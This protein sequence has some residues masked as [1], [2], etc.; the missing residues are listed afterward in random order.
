M[1]EKRIGVIYLTDGN[2][3]D[4]T[5]ASAVALGLN[6]AREI[7][8]HVVQAG[9][10]SEPPPSVLRFLQSKGHRLA[11]H[12]L[13]AVDR[14][15][16]GNRHITP[17]AYAKTEAIAVAS[18]DHDFACYVDNDTLAMRP[19]DLAAVAP[20]KHPFGAAPDLSVSTGFDNPAFF[21]NCDRHGLAK[22]YFNSGLLAINVSRWACSG[23]PERYESAVKAHADFCPYWDGSCTDLDQCALN[24]ATQGQW[25][26]LPVEF[27]VQ[28][29][30]FQ[31]RFW[32]QALI[33]HYTGPEKFLPARS[34]RADRHERAVLG[35]IARAC[36]ELGLE[37][38]A[39]YL[40]LAYWANGL[41]RKAARNRIS[42][43][44]DQYFAI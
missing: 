23:I 43:L 41:R 13:S 14:G 42:R 38:P 6:H 37:I 4:L 21:A 12:S 5:Y 24:I 27:N 31:T 2:R 3:D 32:S 36:P 19:L 26:T 9:F 40:G 34:H 20:R 39:G 30:A 11:I 1:K 10:R 22:R 35:R 44:I 25:E 16:P 15:L 33:R 18:V 29:S 7:D 17:T 8:I 28:K